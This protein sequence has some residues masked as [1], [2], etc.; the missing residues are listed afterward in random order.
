MQKARF[1]RAL[2]ADMRKFVLAAALLAVTGSAFAG[3][4]IWTGKQEQ[5][6]TVT[7]KMVWRCEYRYNGQTL[8]FLFES[9]CPSTV[10]VE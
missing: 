2:G 7:Y 6:R 3:Q 5:V 9:G 8:Y 4:A 10:E 1:L